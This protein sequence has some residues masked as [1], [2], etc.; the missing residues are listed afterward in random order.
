VPAP[1]VVIDHTLTSALAFQKW[2]THSDDSGVKAVNI[3]TMAPHARKTFTIYRKVLKPTVDIGMISI[4]PNDYDA[5]FWWASASGRSWVVR[6]TAGYLYSLL[7]Y[8]SS[9]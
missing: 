2:L 1:Y 5:R 9:G 6:Y 4:Q 7:F 8:R 3:F